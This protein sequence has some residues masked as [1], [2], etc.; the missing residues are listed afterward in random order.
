[1]LHLQL[2]K[3]YIVFQYP[4]SPTKSQDESP[5]LHILKPGL[6]ARMPALGAQLLRLGET[7]ETQGK[8]TPGIAGAPMFVAW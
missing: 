4:Q 6:H 8:G 7:G 3:S 5:R 1:M 2:D